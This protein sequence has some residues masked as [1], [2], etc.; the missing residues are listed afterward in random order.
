MAPA[1]ALKKRE[2]VK[3]I[4]HEGTYENETP[5]AAEFREAINKY[6]KNNERP[7][8]TWSEILE[9]ARALG[10]RHIMPETKMPRYDHETQRIKS[11][12]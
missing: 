12:K 5:E 1:R 2:R 4:L 9:I 11:S 10:Y 8:P 3:I 6:K 7:Y